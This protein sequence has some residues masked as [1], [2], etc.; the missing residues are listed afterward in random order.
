VTTPTEPYVAVIFSSVHTG[1]EVAEYD[2]AA[3]RME[4]LAADQPGYLGIESARGADG[5]GITV[6]YWR[7]ED[8]ARAWKRQSEHLAAQAAGRSTWYARYRVRVATVTRD[9]SYDAGVDPD[10]LLHLA[11]PDDWNAARATGEYRVSTRGRTLTD[12]GFIHCAYRDQFVGVANRFYGDVGEIVILHV[13]PELLDA[14]VRVEP[15]AEGADELF[16]HVYG[17]IP[18]AAVIATTWWDRGDDGVWHR[19]VQF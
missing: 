7:T 10:E 8:D 13:D 4:E 11:L 3:A 15:A 12:E 2:A 14:E 9:Y 18:T 6:S 19:P 16:P 17:P 1:V 5:F